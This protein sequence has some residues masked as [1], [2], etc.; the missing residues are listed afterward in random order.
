[1]LATS[2]DG[3][4]IAAQST[5]HMSRAGAVALRPACTM[6]APFQNVLDS[7]SLAFPVP[8][9]VHLGHVPKDR[10][11]RRAGYVTARECHFGDRTYLSDLEQ[12]IAG[13]RATSA[14]MVDCQMLFRHFP[15]PLSLQPGNE[16]WKC[17]NEP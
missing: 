17:R 1:M 11:C 4:A 9:G 6:V 14:R 7:A 13:R 15:I 5:C 16:P 12:I 8:S 3:G 2:S 10:P